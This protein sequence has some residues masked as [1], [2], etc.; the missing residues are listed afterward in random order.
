MGNDLCSFRRVNVDPRAFAESSV[1]VFEERSKA[2]P[3]RLCDTL[4]I[5][6]E[7]SSG[8]VNKVLGRFLSVCMTLKSV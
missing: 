5:L 4:Q 3:W 6:R 8:C 1:R 7:R 2:F